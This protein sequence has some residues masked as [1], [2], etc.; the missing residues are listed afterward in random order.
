MRAI[1]YYEWVRDLCGYHYLH[2]S[3]LN[4]EMGMFAEKVFTSWLDTRHKHNKRVKAMWLIPRKGRKSTMVTQGGPPWLIAQDPNL[5]IVID[6]E[7]KPRSNDFMTATASI[8]EGIS[9]EPIC[10]PNCKLPKRSWIEY[11]GNWRDPDRQWREDRIEV[12]VRTH[13]QRKEPSMITSSVEIG[14]T[15]GA[16]DCIFIDDPMSPESHTI[17]WMR[18]VI[19]HY[20]G[21]GPVLMPNGL[22]VLCMTRYDDN[23]LA[24]HIERTEGWHIASPDEA[25]RC[26]RRGRCTAATEDHPA[27]WHVMWR[28]AEEDPA[29]DQKPVS[30]DPVIWSDDFLDS[31]KRKNGTFYSAQFLNNPW[32]NP[33]AAFQP[34]DFC[35]AEKVPGD[36]VTVLSTDTAWKDPKDALAQR[37]GDYNTFV[38]GNHQTSTGKVY[39]SAV[40][41]GRW[42]MGEW[43]DQIVRILRKQKR[44]RYRVSRITHEELRV[45]KGAIATAIRSACQRWNEL[46]PALIVAPRSNQK[47]AK[48]ARIKSIAQ[49]FQ[50]HLVIFVRPCGNID[51]DHNYCD[52]PG[53]F[54]MYALRDELL[55]LGSALYDDLADAM[56][57]HFLPD[58]YH[59]PSVKVKEMRPEPRRPY[60]ETLKPN[61]DPTP[62]WRA[63]LDEEDR[64]VYEPTDAFYPREP[65]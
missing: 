56:A 39:V 23:D 51:P 40:G 42:T 9:E 4:R 18:K 54:E 38:T 62:E 61:Y 43:G 30:I 65:V 32:H 14:Y 3:V 22:F 5:A 45:A 44:L 46:T 35:Y 25:E 12:A 41:R 63:T 50:N 8:L 29:S 47:D 52:E 6:S 34:E 59:A 20:T 10:G 33:D 1:P 2:G 19:Q 28:C 49:Y 53:C 24:G 37:G 48:L 13:R 11:M 57:D 17:Q 36:V 27:P 21:L 15:G 31:E 16:P 55:K 64:L 60:D 7:M 58:I 26:I